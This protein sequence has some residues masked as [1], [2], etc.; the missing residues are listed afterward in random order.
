MTVTAR[1]IREIRAVAGD[2]CEY[3]RVSEQNRLI[4]FQIDHIIPLRHGGEDHSE[5]LCLACLE[6][7][8]YKG[9]NVAALDPLTGEATKLYNP[10]LQDWKEHF[11]VNADA[12]LFGL[13]PEGRAT[14]GVLRINA[15]Q[16]RVQRQ[17][18][19]LLGDYPGE[20]M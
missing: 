3:C 8:S 7:H 20:N 5:N 19:L 17:A 16:R 1:Q 14:V 15:G 12:T 18:L 13:T 11:K 2:C 9:P 6:C 10:R 4:G